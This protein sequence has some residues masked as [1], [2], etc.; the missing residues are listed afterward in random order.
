MTGLVELAEEIPYPPSCNHM[1]ALIDYGKES[2]P[3]I[4][5]GRIKSEGIGHCRR[6][7][8]LF[9]VYAIPTDIFVNRLAM[10]L[11]VT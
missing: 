1:G 4:S 8:N 2:M 6:G 3:G 9:R 11:I 7:V 5:F 10:F